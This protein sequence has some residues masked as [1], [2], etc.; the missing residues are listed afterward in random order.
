MGGSIHPAAAQALAAAVAPRRRVN[1]VMVWTGTKYGPE[2]PAILQNMIAR[3]ASNL[4]EDCAWW[5]ITDRPDELPA[6]VYPIEADPTLPTW[7][8]KVRLF[9][10][11]MPWDRGDRCVYFDLDVAITGRLEDLIERKGIIQDWHWPMRNSSVMVWD[12]G[13]HVRIWTDFAHDLIDRPAPDDIKPLLPKGEVNAGDQHWISECAPDWPAFP[14]DWFRSYRDCHAWPPN[15]CKAV[16]FHGAVKPDQVTDG[17]VPNVWKV[18]GFTSL[19]EFKGVNTSEDARLENV[20]INSARD[21]DW[22]TGFKDEGRTCVIACGAPS[23]KDYVQ[24]LKR[25][26]AKGDRIVSVNNA[27]RFLHQRGITPDVNVMLDARPE[28]A[29]FLDGAPKSMRLMLASQCHPS[30]FDK[31]L[32]QGLEVVVWHN[33]WDTGNDKLRE[34]LD[35]WWDGPNQRPCILVPGGSTVGLRSLWLATYSGFRTIHLYGCDSSYADDG[36]HHA[37]AQPLNDHETVLDVVMGAKRYRCAP[38]MVR[39][40]SEFQ[41]SWKDLREYEEEPGKTA[42]VTL[43]VHGRGLVPDVAKQLRAEERGVA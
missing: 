35:P 20:R 3:N 16:I 34:I 26:R 29:A 2:Y 25:H 15:E 39:Q 7:W 24:Q 11:D 12:H 32:E 8:Q 41:Q 10:P 4:E 37:Y 6:G 18:G 17:W 40:A 14:A 28:N 23:M 43:H 9:S 33:G 36:T 19:P 30:V 13:E 42:P 27:W 1:F 22:F 38:W 5:A 31:A 21:L